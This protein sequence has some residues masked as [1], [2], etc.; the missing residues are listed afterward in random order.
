LLGFFSHFLVKGGDDY[1]AGCQYMNLAF[2]KM[3]KDPNRQIYSHVTCA[4]STKNVKFVF[5]S[6]RHSILKDNVN[7]LGIEM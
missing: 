7:D 5:N 2:Q 3:I 1:E 6:V 4:T